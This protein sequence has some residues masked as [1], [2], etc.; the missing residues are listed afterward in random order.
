MREEAEEVY[1]RAAVRAV[2]A[3]H[4]F[5][6]HLVV[7]TGSSWSPAYSLIA[8]AHKRRYGTPLPKR[9][10]LDHLKA[11]DVRGKKVVIFDDVVATGGTLRR[12]GRLISAHKPLDV[13]LLG[14]VERER[15]TQ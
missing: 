4:D 6:P 14:L 3:I 5:S 13:K 2:D 7:V 12:A 8:E 9:K 1:R 15:A 10:H 11:E